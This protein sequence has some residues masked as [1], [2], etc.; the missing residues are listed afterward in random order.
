MSSWTAP[1]T[2]TWFAI[3]L[4][5]NGSRRLLRQKSEELT[6]AQRLAGLGS[7]QWDARTDTVTW[8]EELYRLDGRDPN[9]PAPPFKEQPQPL[10]G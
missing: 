6:E 7:W 5:G 2:S 9:L 8:S 10:H 1:T 3:L 4:N